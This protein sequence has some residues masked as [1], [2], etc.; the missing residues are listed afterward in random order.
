MPLSLQ[1][2]ILRVLQEKEFERIGDTKTRKADVRILA[3]TNKN[4]LDMV[5]EGT[6]REDLYYRIHVIQLHIPPLRERIEDIP[7]LCEFLF[8]K[9]KS[10]SSNK[11]KVLRKTHSQ[12]S[13]STLGQ[14]M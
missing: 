7:L 14:A 2:K 12:N 8:D 3:A 10:K 11:L 4:L 13:H 1:V 6:F 9:F 5:R